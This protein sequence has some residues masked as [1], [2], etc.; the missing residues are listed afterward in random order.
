MEVRALEDTRLI[1]LVL[2][3]KALKILQYDGEANTTNMHFHHFS[4]CPV[5]FFMLYLYY[6]YAPRTSLTVHNI[7]VSITLSG[8]LKGN[9]TKLWPCQL[10]CA[11][12]DATHIVRGVL[13]SARRHTV[14][15]VY[16][17]C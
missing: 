12:E 16:H 17:L 10:A 2:C 15:E 4:A 14:K 1:N 11:F 7:A 6:N 8:C 5:Y 3:L 13:S 9:V